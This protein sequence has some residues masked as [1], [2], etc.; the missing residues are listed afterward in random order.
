MVGH[1][2]K[3][4]CVKLFGSEKGAITGSADRSIKVWD[5]SRQTYKQA[6]TLRHSSTANSVDV[7]ADL[8]TAV[9]GHL[10]GGIRLFHLQTGERLSDL[11]ELHRG[12][13]T[14]VRFH[15]LDASKVLTNGMDSTLK[16]SDIRARVPLRTFA[17]PRFRTSYGWA[18]ASF[19]PD[20]RYAGA[21][22][23]TGDVL[24]WD[25]DTGDLRATLPDH[26]TCVCGFDWGRGGSSGQQV[27]SVDKS[28]VLT[29]WS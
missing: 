9:T 26:P 15:P 12:A 2:H 7:S 25:A 22:S 17:D 13:V 29:L 20:G 3:I 21:G 16:I 5:I 6:A 14:S 28:G 24:V 23:A 4:T 27:A 10:D 11:P 19:S 1:A 8:F 18:S